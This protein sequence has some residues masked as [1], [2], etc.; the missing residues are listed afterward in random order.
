M[1][2]ACPNQSP[3]Q[4]PNIILSSRVETSLAYPDQ[5]SSAFLTPE[6][7]IQDKHIPNEHHISE[8]LEPIFWVKNTYFFHY[9]FG[10]ARVCWPLLCLCRPFCVFE[11]CLDSTLIATVASGRATNL[12][13]HLPNLATHLPDWILDPAWEK[14]QIRD[15]G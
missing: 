3:E 9:F 2:P 14:I 4:D 6:S 1:R 15:P 7:S 11:I 8:S 13:T 10:G 5:G 12:A